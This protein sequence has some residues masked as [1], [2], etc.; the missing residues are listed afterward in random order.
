MPWFQFPTAFTWATSL[1]QPRVLLTDVLHGTWTTHPASPPIVGASPIIN[2]MFP[3]SL[4]RQVI[5]G[6][7][8][9]FKVILA[10][11]Q[12]FLSMYIYIHTQQLHVTRLLL[13]L[14]RGF[15]LVSLHGRALVESF[16]L[17]AAWLQEGSVTQISLFYD[18]R[19]QKP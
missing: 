1:K 4:Y 19:L 9:Y 15:S 2:I 17:A 8:T 18:L 13:L 3:D 11:I 7:K 6:L 5:L 16:R 10:I 14:S 12:A